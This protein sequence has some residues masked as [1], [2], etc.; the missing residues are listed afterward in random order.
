LFLS[1]HHPAGD[2]AHNSAIAA[3]QILD[4]VNEVADA[5]DRPQRAGHTDRE[6]VVAQAKREPRRRSCLAVG[7]EDSRIGAESNQVLQGVGHDAL[8]GFGGIVPLLLRR[9]EKGLRSF[10]PAERPGRELTIDHEPHM[11]DQGDSKE[12]SHQRREWIDVV[13]VAVNERDATATCPSGKTP[14]GHEGREGS[15]PVGPRHGRDD[16]RNRVRVQPFTE[17]ASALDGDARLNVLPGAEGDPTQENP[18]RPRQ[19]RVVREVQNG[20]LAGSR[21]A[22]L[23][24]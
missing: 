14:G 19:S 17:G 6:R 11:A 21:A 9:P 8:D 16:Q 22:I 4:Q 7:V 2:E 12:A 1:W 23:R 13:F 15:S 5:F 10:P 20:H 3:A 24:H 18:R